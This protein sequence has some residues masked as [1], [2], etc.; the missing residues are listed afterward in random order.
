MDK[1]EYRK[2]LIEDLGIHFENEYSL[3]PLSARI[4]A[5]LI[6][7]EEDGLTFDDCLTRRGASKSSISTSLNLL[8]Q[9]GFIKYFTKS[10]DRK[11]YYTVAAKDSFMVKKLSK[12]LK[13]LENEEKMMGKLADYN[14]K[15]NP[16]KFKSSQKMK[17][18]YMNCLKE[19]KDIFQKTIDQ[20]N[21]LKE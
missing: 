21:T 17:K 7:T 1:E 20:L 12:A 8:L 15:F 11:R 4:F 5:S 6:M 13:Q 18:I 3:P 14:E 19:Q 2:G 10:R 16:E 9:M